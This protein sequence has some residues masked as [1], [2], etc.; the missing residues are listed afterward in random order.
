[1]T[2]SGV[3]QQAW[4]PVLS[5]GAST[6][7][8]RRSVMTQQQ[9]QPWLFAPGERVFASSSTLPPVSTLVTC[10]SDVGLSKG[11]ESPATISGT[12]AATAYVSAAAAHL[13]ARAPQGPVGL[14]WRAADLARLLFLTGEPICEAAEG[15][16][17]RDSIGRNRISI[18]RADQALTSGSS[19]CAALR[20]CL[21]SSAHPTG[22]MVGA[23]TAPVCAAGMSACFGSLA[24][25]K[26]SSI[27][28][29]PGWTTGQYANV[30]SASLSCRAAWNAPMGPPTAR[31][32]GSNAAFPEV[33][34]AGIGPQPSG[35]GCPNCSVLV[36]P[37]SGI[38]V[39][40][41]L[42][43]AFPEG[44]RFLDAHLALLTDDKYAVTY[45]PISDGREWRPGEVGRI[46]L[47]L[48]AELER[49]LA[50]YLLAEWWIPVFDLGVEIDGREARF[51][52]P[53]RVQ[54]VERL[55]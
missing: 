43:D 11:F 15:A 12:S 19:G 20:A 50:E 53:L 36:T 25:P 49:M 3:L 51:L 23:L 16:S 5:V 37:W 9:G 7:D 48:P 54:F 30:G 44:T 39:E 41:E 40:F 22:P 32:T 31:L 52:S 38:W 6:Y 8:D 28:K 24:F 29:E 26:C 42:S 14:G 2:S 55:E 35:S 17:Y 33:Q 21:R 45:L 10:G 34:L 47:E 18:S 46:K 4:L 13:I 1:L 27:G